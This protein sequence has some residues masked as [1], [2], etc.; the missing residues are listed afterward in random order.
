MISITVTNAYINKA[1]YWGRM[2][3]IFNLNA[4]HS[5]PETKIYAQ[6]NNR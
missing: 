2:A 3:T 6:R 1:D 4:Y 5:S